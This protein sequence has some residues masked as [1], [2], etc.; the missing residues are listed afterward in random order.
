MAHVA[1]SGISGMC[2]RGKLINKR[3]IVDTSI[4]ALKII[5]DGC[6]QEPHGMFT[7]DYREDECG[8]PKI[9]E[10]NIRHVSFTLAFALCGA[11]FA[12]DSL[13]LY[14]N[15]SSFDRVFKIYEF[16]DDYTFIRG[17]DAQI[18]VLKDSEI[19]SFIS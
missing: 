1:P 7:V 2:S 19:K 6:G 17:V 15:D 10:I 18:Q 16:D 4:K 8:N 3:E 14:L 9:T 13:R 5:F 12:E 11:N